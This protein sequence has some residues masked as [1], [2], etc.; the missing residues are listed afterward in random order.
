[1]VNV[2]LSVFHL[3]DVSLSEPHP[4]LLQFLRCYFFSTLARMLEKL[5]HEDLIPYICFQ[6]C[7]LAFLVLSRNLE[8]NGSHLYLL[9]Y[10]LHHGNLR[11]SKYLCLVILLGDIERTPYH[12]MP[13]RGDMPL[14]NHRLLRYHH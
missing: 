12:A 1:M 3:S 5:G 9:R 11:S 13:H 14:I 4:R 8:D 10:H 6:V 2:Q 7:Q